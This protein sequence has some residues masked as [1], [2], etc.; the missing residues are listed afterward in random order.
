MIESYN[1]II[2]G[3]F[4]QIGWFEIMER[5]ANGVLKI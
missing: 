4:E 5:E 2:V 3:V 1:S